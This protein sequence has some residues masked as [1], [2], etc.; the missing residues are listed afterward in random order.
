VSHNTQHIEKG[1]SN[2]NFSVVGHE[3]LS[4]RKGHISPLKVVVSSTAKILNHH[5]P[6]RDQMQNVVKVQNIIGLQNAQD[7]VQGKANLQKSS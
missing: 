1:Q 5:Q 6:Q 7:Q 2:E 3:I 4:S